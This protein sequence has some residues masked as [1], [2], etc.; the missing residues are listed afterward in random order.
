M[1]SINPLNG[2]LEIVQPFFYHS[3]Y[4]EIDKIDVSIDTGID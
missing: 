3:I 4:L 2:L 1:L